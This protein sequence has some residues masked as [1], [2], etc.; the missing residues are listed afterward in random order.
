MHTVY[1][2]YFR[3]VTARAE[4]V[5]S[6]SPGVR[7]IWNTTVPPECVASVT[8]EFRTSSRGPVANKT[9]TNTSQ[10]EVIQTDLQCAANYYIYQ[11]HLK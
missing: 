10:H 11:S 1:Q 8:V 7:V 5:G 4:S 2:F 9:T 3:P 6:S